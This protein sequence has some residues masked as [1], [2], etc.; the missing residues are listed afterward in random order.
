LNANVPAYNLGAMRF[1]ERHGFSV[2]VRRRLAVARDGQRW[3]VVQYG[4]LRGEWQDRA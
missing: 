1:L 4:L 2:E 3:D